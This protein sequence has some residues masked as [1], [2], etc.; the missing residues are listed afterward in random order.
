MIQVEA[1]TVN[2][3]DRYQLEGVYGPISFPFTGGK[4]G[5]GRVIEANGEDVQNWIGKRVVFSSGAGGVW[6]SFVISNPSF[7][8]EIDEDVP[9]SCAASGVINPLTTIGFIETFKHLG[10]K[11]GIIHTAAASSLG[12]QLNRLAKKEGIPILNLVRRQEQ[13]DLLKS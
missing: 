7:T 12:R 1:S 9:L 11:G 2:P 8:F 5:T 3:S 6:A 13:L 10:K 4:E